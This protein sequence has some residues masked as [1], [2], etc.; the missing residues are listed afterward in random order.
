MHHCLT[1]SHLLFS[2]ATFPRHLGTACQFRQFD[3]T[4]TLLVLI[5]FL[6]T[7]PCTDFRSTL[8]S[9]YTFLVST[10]SYAKHTINNGL[11]TWRHDVVVI[12]AAQL[13]STKPKLRFY[14]GQSSAGDV[15]EIHDGKDHWHFFRLERG[16][17][18]VRR[19]SIPQKTNH[20][21][22]NNLF[23]EDVRAERC[24]YELGHLHITT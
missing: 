21:H 7:F 14:A 22:Y 16:L 6:S 24:D 5:T 23:T 4:T 19:S 13:H 1:A 2:H 20:H 11:I 18:A 12:T 9:Q 15:L 17:N 10:T 8:F 3:D